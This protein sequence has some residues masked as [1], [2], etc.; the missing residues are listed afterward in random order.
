MDLHLNESSR[1]SRLGGP[2]TP[3]VNRRRFVNRVSEPAQWYFRCGRFFAVGHEWYATTR[4][5]Y[6]VG[7]YASRQEAELELAQFIAHEAPD[8]SAKTLFLSP[9]DSR[10]VTILEILVHEFL[11]CR[12]ETSIRSENSAF[13]WL[14]TR[15]TAIE[16]NPETL[17]HPEV[18]ATAIR[19]LIAQL[20]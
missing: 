7:P 15:L 2:E 10:E 16:E 12:Y 6:D 5:G 17:D 18:R 3:R 14:K 13:A 19:R 4:E 20:E 8:V 11:I 1:P 9:T